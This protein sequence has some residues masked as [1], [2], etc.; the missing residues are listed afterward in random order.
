MI[1]LNSSIKRQRFT[2]WVKKQNTMLYS[3]QEIHLIQKNNLWAKIKGC[4]NNKK[5][6]HTPG[7][8][9]QARVG[10]LVS[11]KIE[12]KPKSIKR[13]KKGHYIV[14]LGIIQQEEITIIIRYVPNWYN[15]LHETNTTGKNNQIIINTIIVRK[16]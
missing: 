5:Q 1:G 8:P 15:Q 16:P 9:K 4:N 12:S 7:L 6:L 11:E 14:V 13:G 2:D 3:I 10:I